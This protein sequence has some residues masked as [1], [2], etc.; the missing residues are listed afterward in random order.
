MTALGWFARNFYVA[1][2]KGRGILKFYSATVYVC[3][4]NLLTNF[5]IVLS[6]ANNGFVVMGIEVAGVV[7]AA[8]A[9]EIVAVANAEFVELVGFYAVAPDFVL[10]YSIEEVDLPYADELD[11][12]E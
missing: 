10:D 5:G 12:H 2:E 7:A 11:S 8:V 6:E 1:L 4:S 9:S 3:K